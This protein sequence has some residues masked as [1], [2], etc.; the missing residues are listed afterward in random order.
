M[1]AQR[2]AL[3][4][5]C[6]TQSW[7]KNTVNRF[8]RLFCSFITWTIRALS[9]SHIMSTLMKNEQITTKQRKVKIPERS[10][11]THR[12]LPLGDRP[13]LKSF[14][15]TNL[16]WTMLGTLEYRNDLELRVEHLLIYDSA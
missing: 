12:D 15:T 14:Q 2:G 6:G 16:G 8:L 5:P 11:A 1:C 9:R 13:F 4:G 3:T 7:E 10:P